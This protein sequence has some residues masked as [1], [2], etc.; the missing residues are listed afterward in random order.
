MIKTIKEAEPD[1]P[2]GGDHGCF[3]ELQLS[4]LF[5][6]LPVRWFSIIEINIDY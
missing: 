3:C 6:L 5:L 1:L 2:K 4:D